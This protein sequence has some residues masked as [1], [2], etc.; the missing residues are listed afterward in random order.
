MLNVNIKM[1]IFGVTVVLYFTINYSGLF[2][3]YLKKDILNV[4]VYYVV[5]HCYVFKTFLKFQSFNLLV[6]IRLNVMPP[7]C[8]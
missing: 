6:P 5:G 7:A 1:F 3:N 8:G 4:V 2:L